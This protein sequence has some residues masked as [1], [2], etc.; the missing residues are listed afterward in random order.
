MMQPA[1]LLRLV[2]LLSVVVMIGLL[3]GGAT[4]QA[5]NMPVLNLPLNVPPIPGRPPA[6]RP[7]SIEVDPSGIEGQVYRGVKVTVTSNSGPVTANRSL[8]VVLSANGYSER[9]RCDERVTA[10]IDV[11]EGQ[12]SATVW[13]DV[14]QRRQ[15]HWMLVEFYEDGEPLKNCAA[16][17][18][19]ANTSF[20]SGFNDSAGL[21]VIS[22]H[23]PTRNEHR[24]GGC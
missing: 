21:L 13:V 22:Q 19:I 7:W 12:S 23:A 9:G 3:V 4:A 8:R 16:G 1:A 24:A 20:R 10:F 15:W 11:P 18:S 6:P 17:M 2:L 14:P 5:E